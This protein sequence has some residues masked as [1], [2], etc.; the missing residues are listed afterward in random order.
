MNPD[1][2]ALKN[3]S[4]FYDR[5]VSETALPDLKTKEGNQIHLD[6]IVDFKA[7]IEKLDQKIEE[8]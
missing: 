8:L 4:E 6:F 5:C 7:A 2:Q 3:I 1:K